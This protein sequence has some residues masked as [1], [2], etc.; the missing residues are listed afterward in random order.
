LKIA[1]TTKN[2]K[3]LED[4]VSEDFA[5]SPTITIVEV[6]LKRRSYRLVGILEN[7]AS[8]FGHGAGPVFVYILMKNNVDAVVGPSEVGMGVKE[9]LDELKIRLIK[10]E[11][12]IK[13]KEVI[14]DIISESA[15]PG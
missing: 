8:R 11:A 14:E 2:F 7:D 9:L 5:R 15:R 4:E 1:V 12:G 10:S 6:D 3:G 13:V